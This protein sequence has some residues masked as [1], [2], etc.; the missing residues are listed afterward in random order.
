MEEKG[1]AIKFVV[2]KLVKQNTLRCFDHIEGMQREDLTKKMYDTDVEGEGE[3]GN[4]STE[5]KN[6][7]ET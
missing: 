4:G 3:Q 6:V 5:W 7:R 1:R 2:V